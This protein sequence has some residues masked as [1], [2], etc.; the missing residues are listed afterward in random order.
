M[1]PQVGRIIIDQLRRIDFEPYRLWKPPLDA[2]WSIEKLV[3]TYLGRPWDSDYARTPNLVFPVG[4]VDRP[5]KHDQHPL[6]IDVSGPGGNVVIVGAQGSGKTTALQDLIC[7]AAMTHTPEQVQFYCLAFSSA[8]LSSVSGLPHVG[9]VSMSLDSDGVR[10]TVAEI[11]ALLASRKRSFE[12]TGVM[13][14]EVFRRRKAGREPGAVPED[15]YGDVF[16]VI[17]NYAAMVS[18]YEAL[19]EDK[20]NRII[21]EG[22]TFGI[23]VVAAVTKNTDLQVTVRGNFR[24]SGGASSGRLQRSDAGG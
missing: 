13:S 7:A 24:V 17:D 1:R 6:T 5:F 12:A 15:G 20:V 21:K 10:R 16:L 8:A 11:A 18:E 9:G 14:M 4:L 22:P 19:V 23:H 3:N 2:P